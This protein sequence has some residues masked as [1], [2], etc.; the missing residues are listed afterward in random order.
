MPSAPPTSGGPVTEALRAAD[1][2][3]M[4]KSK[5]HRTA[6]TLFAHLREEK[7][8]FALAGALALNVYGVR[9]M[10]E[11]V[12][13]L[14]TPEGMRQFK[15]RWLG[16]GYVE[17]RRGS[18]AVR[19]T[20]TRV[21]IDFLLAGEFPGDSRPKPVE[22]PNPKDRVELIEGTPVLP[23]PTLIELKLASGMTAKDRPQDYADVIR[24]IRARSLPRDFADQLNP[25]VR[26]KFDELW[27]AAQLPSDD[28]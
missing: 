18:K 26:S 14:I 5:V 27:E 16:R 25:F 15:E 7:I 20:E 4:G 22:F 24:L 3:F 12:D 17:I 19:D 9:R 8:D 1:E 21:K 6:E 23:L 2:F 28:Y 11:D 13:I 10:T